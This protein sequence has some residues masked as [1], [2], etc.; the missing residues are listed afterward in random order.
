MIE[1]SLCVTSYNRPERLR[2][3]LSSFFVT[4]LYDLN[5]LELIIVDN[6]STDKAVTDFIKSYSPDCKYTYILN[7]KNDYP[8]CLRY[9][10]IQAR[11]IA[12]G[13]YFIDCPDDHV[14]VA[15]AP[16]IEECIA[17]I[18]SEPTVGCINH[19]AF[20]FY[21]FGK[22]NNKMVIDKNNPNF[23]VSSLKGY[24]DFHVMSRQTYENIG[25]Y[26]YKLG[27]HAEG[28]YMKRSLDKG[29]FRNLMVNPV[30]ICMD[31][32]K[33]GEGKNGFRLL[34]PIEKDDYNSRLIEFMRKRYPFR[35]SFPIHNEALIY[36]C[37]KNGHIE[38][39]I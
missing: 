7:E 33:F 8:N 3:V 30:S 5:K 2:E 13:K 38:V 23:S 34:K 4:N 31:D 29:Y 17:R 39:K 20:P 36:F 9:S 25:E 12:E 6:G 10:K 14:F 27:R 11:E 24:S 35:A 1:T 16:W 28:E 37:I 19:Y 26:E 15:K 21:R 18:D 32:G 22:Q